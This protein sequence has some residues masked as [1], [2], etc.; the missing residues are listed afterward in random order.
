MSTPVQKKSDGYKIGL[1]EL[2]SNYIALPVDFDFTTDAAQVLTK[3]F[4]SEEQNLKIPFIQGVFI[5]NS[6]D[7]NA[8][9]LAVD[10]LP[11]HS[12]TVKGHTQGFYPLICGDG[13]T[14][15][16]VTSTGSAAVKRIIFLSMPVMPCQWAT[17]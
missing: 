6:G 4:V 15:I 12:I 7:A 14:R 11:G 8:L 3:D 10:G 5:D 13:P 1:M 2:P 17:A 9:T 16:T